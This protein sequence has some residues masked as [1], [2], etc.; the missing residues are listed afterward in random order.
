[1]ER[2]FDYA[3]A[4]V[5]WG[6]WLRQWH[7]TREGRALRTAF[8]CERIAKEKSA[9]WQ[10]ELKASQSVWA[11]RAERTAQEELGLHQIM[12]Q[13]RRDQRLLHTEIM[14]TVLSPNDGFGDE[15][16]HSSEPTPIADRRRLRRNSR[17][18][19]A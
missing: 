17:F 10:A 7:H 12:R 16:R 6:Q 19:K 2:A 1:M 8:A 9:V 18:T 13:I 4:L 14:A 5:V 15:S 3:R 11:A